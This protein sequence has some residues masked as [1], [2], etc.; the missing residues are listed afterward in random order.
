MNN[1]QIKEMYTDVL[2]VCNKYED[3]D[4]TNYRFSDVKDM[5]IKALDHL[6]VVEWSEKFGI[7]LNHD[8]RPYSNK[9]IRLSPDNLSF[10]KYDDGMKDKNI[11]SSKY[12]SWSDDG[13]QP[14]DEWLF[15]ASFPTGAYIFGDNY[16]QQQ[17]LFQEFFN[18]LKEYK[19]DYSDT[20]NHAL[21]WKMDNCKEIYNK[22]KEIL[23]KY[24]DKNR[25]EFTAR[26]K[27]RLEK[28]L[29]S[30]N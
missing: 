21:Y 27:E 14:K 17:D 10:S 30:L 16:E 8:L 5:K 6:M 9:H 3:I 20:T 12:I 18:E 4:D 26:K 2:G 15:I 1:K 13:K 11:G 7:E 24:Q 19:P 22:Y 28:E 25:E 23:Q 29:A